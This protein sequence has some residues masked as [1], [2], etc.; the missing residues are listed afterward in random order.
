MT[1]VS[2]RWWRRIVARK[3]GPSQRLYISLGCKGG[4]VPCYDQEGV[5]RVFCADDLIDVH[6]EMA[7]RMPRDFQRVYWIERQSAIEICM[8][9]FIEVDP[10][11]SR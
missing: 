1:R 3:G 11:G 10:L 7:K 2:A 6:D 5:R 4:K 9:G 8:K